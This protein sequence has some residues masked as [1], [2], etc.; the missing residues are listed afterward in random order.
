[1]KIELYGKLENSLPIEYKGIDLSSS[2]FREALIE[3]FWGRSPLCAVIGPGGCGKSVLLKATAARFRDKAL[4]MAPTGVAARNISGGEIVAGTIH[5]MLGIPVLDGRN[6]GGDYRFW[7]EACDN[8][9][10]AFL[11]VDV[12]LIDE[13]S[14]VSA[15]LFDYIMHQ[16]YLAS[17]IRGSMIRVICFGDPMQ[18]P[19]VPN[20][21][22][23]AQKR[24]PDMFF[25][26]YHWKALHPRVFRLEKVM[27]QGSGQE[28]FKDVLRE[29]RLNVP[30]TVLEGRARSFI[31]GIYGKGLPETGEVTILTPYRTDRTLPDGKTYRGCESLNRLILDEMIKSGKVEEEAVIC[32]P[33]VV[34][35]NRTF[36]ASEA[37]LSQFE[38]GNRL[39]DFSFHVGQRVMCTRNAA[40]GTYVNGSVGT[41]TGFGNVR[42]TGGSKCLDENGYVGLRL[43]NG[44]DC[45]IYP[46]D[47][48]LP[49][50]VDSDSV[51]HERITCRIIPLQPAYAMTY[52][53]AQGLTMDRVVLYTDGMFAE[54]MLYIGMSR[55]RT[56]QGLYMVG[57]PSSV[58]SPKYDRTSEAGLGFLRSVGRES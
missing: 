33:L 50:V 48:T 34:K 41:I 18:L 7:P 2:P 8:A 25:D 46:C 11:R 49:E 15:N 36:P 28:E 45:T 13:I 23:R 14:M 5:R 39:S 43:D 19:P 17:A 51:R 22:E 42:E 53:K 3:A 32:R 47:Y 31:K 20:A 54:G 6:N 56:A 27:R 55:V 4:C 38:F 10:D 21:E 30:G 12:V 52:H 35:D 40:D 24:N 37:D 16:V 26:S 1:M 57:D 29:V 58:D 44:T 9:I